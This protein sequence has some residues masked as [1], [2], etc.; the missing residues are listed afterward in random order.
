MQNELR[1]KCVYTS[2]VDPF[3]GVVGPVVDLLLF[4]EPQVDF[5]LGRF[6]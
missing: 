6:D 1:N 2:F 3:F 4:F 5:S